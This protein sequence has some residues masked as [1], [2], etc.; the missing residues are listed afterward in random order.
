MAGRSVVHLTLAVLLLAVAPGS[1]AVSSSFF[2]AL[3]GF[4]GS[5]T[6]S[7]GVN[8]EGTHWAL[9]IA[10]SAGYG[11]YRHQA[12]VAHAYQVLK[13][14]GLQE[15]HIVVMMADDVA[16]SFENPH[17]GEL[18]NRPKGPNVYAGLKPDYTGF[19]VTAKNFLAVLAGDKKSLEPGAEGGKLITSGPNDRVFV[20]YADH[21]APGIMGMPTGPFLYADQLI[22]T[23][24]QKAKRRE[25]KEMVLFIEACESGSMFEGLLNAELPIYVTTA[26]NAHESSWGTYCPGMDPSPPPEFTTCLGDLYSVAWL[27]EVDALMRADALSSETLH[28][29]Y[30]D[31]KRRTSNNFTYSMGSHVM[32]YGNLAISE[33]PVSNA[34]QEDGPQPSAPVVELLDSSAAEELDMAAGLRVDAHESITARDAE[35]LHLWTKYNRAAGADKDDALEALNV[36]IGSRRTA[37]KAIRSALKL[38]L[39]A[40]N[41]AMGAL[42]SKLLHAATQQPANGGAGGVPGVEHM[43][44][45]AVTLA[46]GAGTGPVT[47]DWDCLRGMVAEWEGACGAMDGYSMKYVGALANLCNSGVSPQTLGAVLPSACTPQAQLAA[48]AAV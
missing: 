38:L 20:Y 36:A 45:L 8:E 14:A 21:G 16:Y 39:Q 25:F 18:Y 33:E 4:V 32:Q 12:D 29:L 10:G 7:S 26:A 47:R 43:V 44:E 13:R 31:V 37:D 46:P 42:Q 48:A 28:Q 40:N 5:L 11:N 22:D 2:D 9:L 34:I 3:A 41:E 1:L 6:T 19:K 27:E 23:L 15:E 30:E 24:E 35:L 17:P